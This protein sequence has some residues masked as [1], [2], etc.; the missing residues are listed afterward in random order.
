MSEDEVEIE[1]DDEEY[2]VVPLSPIR[3]LEKR[4]DELEEKKETKGGTEFVQE[5][6]SLIK[7]NQRMVEEMVKSN[8]DL[9]NELSGLP[10]KIEEVTNQWKEFL[11]ILEKGVGAGASLGGE[12][13][14]SDLQQ[15]VELNKDLIEKN[16]QVVD[17]LQSLERSLEGGSVGGRES[18][19]ERESP[20]VRVRRERSGTEGMRDERRDRG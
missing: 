14:S 20:R 12:E 4:I 1:A 15:L 11:E 18:R 17:S 3:K 5:M 6:M 13:A 10:K 7:A 2:E 9:R 19:N 8:N 16:E